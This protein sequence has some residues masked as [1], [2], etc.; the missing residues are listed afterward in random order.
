M[1]QIDLLIYC[2]VAQVSRAPVYSSQFELMVQHG[3]VCIRVGFKPLKAVKADIHAVITFPRLLDLK[4]TP[5]TVVLFHVSP[6]RRGC[7]AIVVLSS[8]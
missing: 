7:F 6:G 3:P 8:G 4:T 2:R 5:S 1:C